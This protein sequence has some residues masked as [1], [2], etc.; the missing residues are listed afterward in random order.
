MDY[1]RLNLAV[2]YNIPAEDIDYLGSGTH[3]EM[4]SQRK[5]CRSDERRG[6]KSK[7]P[8]DRSAG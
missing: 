2:Q 1:T 3:E 4:E 8:A 5:A 6:R 7:S